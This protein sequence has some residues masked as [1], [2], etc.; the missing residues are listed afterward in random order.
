MKNNPS[1]TTGLLPSSVQSED[2]TS[3]SE[4]DHSD[5]L[6]SLMD[7]GGD[8]GGGE[9]MVPIDFDEMKKVTHND[10]TISDLAEDMS[11]L[12]GSTRMMIN[13]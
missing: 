4:G 12:H 13:R 10:P 5:P 2:G 7:F 1:E 6:A 8:A 11:K 3:S 9:D